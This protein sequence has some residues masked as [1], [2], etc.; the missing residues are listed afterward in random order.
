MGS[1]IQDSAES[2]REFWNSF[3]HDEHGNV[4]LQD[5]ARDEV[6]PGTPD[7]EI[8]AITN[9]FKSGELTLA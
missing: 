8:M 3:P 1:R 7:P 5:H 2:L 6:I 9:R 4:I